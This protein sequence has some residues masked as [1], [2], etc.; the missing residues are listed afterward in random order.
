[1]Q[2]PLGLEYSSARYTSFIPKTIDKSG[3]CGNT[4]SDVRR[5]YRTVEN[6][7]KGEPLTAV[8]SGTRNNNIQI[9]ITS[10]RLDY[11][12]IFLFQDR[13]DACQSSRISILERKKRGN[14]RR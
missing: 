4:R 1:M 10:K 9:R 11:Q 14:G 3:Y 8:M 13:F 6:G 12:Q 5:F 2:R 7:V